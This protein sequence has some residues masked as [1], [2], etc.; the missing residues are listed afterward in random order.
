M[1][2]R[3]MLADALGWRPNWGEFKV[4]APLGGRTELRQSRLASYR[5]AAKSTLISP[6]RQRSLGFPSLLS[7]AALISGGI[8]ASVATH[9]AVRP[10]GGIIVVFHSN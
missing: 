10:L 3:G 8:Y 4:R 6:M 5:D 9:Q 1:L 7:S 2:L